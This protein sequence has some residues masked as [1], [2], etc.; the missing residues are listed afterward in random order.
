MLLINGK[1]SMIATRIMVKEIFD[2]LLNELP[3]GWIAKFDKQDDIIVVLGPNNAM[4]NI[5]CIKKNKTSVLGVWP[6][7]KYGE[8]MDPYEWGVLDLS[9]KYPL[10]RLC[11]LDGAETNIN[12]L[13]TY[14]VDYNSIYHKCLNKYS[15]N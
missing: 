2:L 14:I 11:M 4:I 13:L 9:D 12:N 15:L 7:N 6:Q 10:M 1:L 5:K 8:K 3:E